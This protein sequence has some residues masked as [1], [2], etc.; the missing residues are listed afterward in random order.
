[1]GRGAGGGRPPKPLSLLKLDGTYTRSRHA[2]RIDDSLFDG[3]PKKANWLAFEAKRFWKW[4]VEPLIEKGVATEADSATLQA[5]AQLWARWRWADQQCS[6]C[7]HDVYDFARWT[8]VSTSLIQR[9]DNLASRFGMTPVDRARLRV[10][11][12]EQPDDNEERFFA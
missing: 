5:M 4:Q 8:R 12:T 3:K 1:M 7:L 9:F 11:P 2:N 10:Q 6:E